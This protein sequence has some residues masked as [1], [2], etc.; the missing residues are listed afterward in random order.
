MTV[1][2]RD[3]VELLGVDHEKVGAVV[4]DLTDGLTPGDVTLDPDPDA[5][6]SH[7]P[8]SMGFAAEEPDG[9]PLTRDSKSSSPALLVASN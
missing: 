4:G 8:A 1:A 5:M 6:P 3:G 9:L 2:G 7:P